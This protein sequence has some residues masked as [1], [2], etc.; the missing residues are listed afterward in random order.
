[1][2]DERRG[3]YK[4][5]YIVVL[6]PL[7]VSD[8]WNFIIVIRCFWETFA[9]ERVDSEDSDWEKDFGRFVFV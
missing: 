9:K 4:C 3:A 2:F 1:M 8:Q 5:K 7:H 6:S